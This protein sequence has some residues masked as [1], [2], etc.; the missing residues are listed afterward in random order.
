[1][2]KRLK[3]VNFPKKKTITKIKRSLKIKFHQV[4]MKKIS[5]KELKSLSKKDFG[6]LL[7]FVIRK[8]L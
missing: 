6:E 2:K 5:I 3:K 1:M 4:I 7:Y 8:Y